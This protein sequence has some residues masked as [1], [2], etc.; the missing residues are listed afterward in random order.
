M[1][2]ASSL[3]QVELR[4]QRSGRR[5]VT[6]TNDPEGD[7]DKSQQQLEFAT[8]FL[9]LMKFMDLEGQNLIPFS[10]RY[11]NM[12][13]SFYPRYIMFSQEVIGVFL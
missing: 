8:I 2:A 10:S 12:N 5:P 1:A 3:E 11:L 4:P 7:N 13:W 9:Q 6:F